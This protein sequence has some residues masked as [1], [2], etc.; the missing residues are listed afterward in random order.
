LVLFSFA[1]NALSPIHFQI[2]SRSIGLRSAALRPHAV[3][4]EPH[5]EDTKAP[6]GAEAGLLCRRNNLERS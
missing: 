3:R 5:P 2:I 1:Y 6:A 4:Q